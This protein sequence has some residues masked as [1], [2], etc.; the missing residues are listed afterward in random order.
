MSFF[1]LSGLNVLVLDFNMFF[2]SLLL[3]PPFLACTLERSVYGCLQLIVSMHWSELT[4]PCVLDN[5]CKKKD[6]VHDA[7]GTQV[8]PLIVLVE[9]CLL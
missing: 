4:L 3:S 5:A 7:L 9:W 1:C 6:A 8:E 2:C